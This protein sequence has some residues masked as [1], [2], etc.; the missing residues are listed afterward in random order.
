[1]TRGDVG[2]AVPITY[3][4]NWGAFFVGKRLVNNKQ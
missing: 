4:V 1:M 3:R 2:I